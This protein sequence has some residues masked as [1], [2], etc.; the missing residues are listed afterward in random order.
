MK[1]KSGKGFDGHLKL[2]ASGRLDLEFAAK[3]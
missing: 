1:G 2:T 3:K